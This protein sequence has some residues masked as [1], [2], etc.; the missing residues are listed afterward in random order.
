MPDSWL[1]GLFWLPES[2]SAE[3]QAPPE[4]S[5]ALL[6][7]PTH[8]ASLIY[9]PPSRQIEDEPLRALLA[10]PPQPRHTG[11]SA[12]SAGQVGAARPPV[13]VEEHK[14]TACM[15]CRTAKRAC[16]KT[17]PCERWV[18]M[19]HKERR[20]TYAAA[21]EESFGSSHRPCACTLSFSLVLQV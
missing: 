17:L 15:A 3:A 7:P 16:S 20:P 6:P 14:A 1:K 12:A 13:R 11:G 4:L 18:P 9:V 8:P 5:P 19:P 2:Y 10:Q 21:W